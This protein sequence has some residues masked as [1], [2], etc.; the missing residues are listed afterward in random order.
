MSSS[1]SAL[2]LLDT[3]YDEPNVNLSQVQLQLHTIYWQCWLVMHILIDI[4]LGIDAELSMHCA[5]VHHYTHYLNIK[6]Y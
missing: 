4:I 3:A 2:G 6:S 5:Q 1:V